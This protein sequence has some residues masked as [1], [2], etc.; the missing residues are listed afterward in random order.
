MSNPH[1]VPNLN[2]SQPSA[3]NATLLPTTILVTNTTDETELLRRLLP[4]NTLEE[5]PAHFDIFGALVITNP[6]GGE[7]LT[8][9]AY[10]GATVLADFSFPVVVAPAGAT[11]EIHWW[12]SVYHR[13]P[14][15][16]APMFCTVHRGLTGVFSPLDLYS[17]EDGIGSEAIDAALIYRFTAEFD[18]ATLNSSLSITSGIM[19]QG[20]L[21]PG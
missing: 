19:D 7:T 15:Q 2:P 8:L 9:R 6:A 16:I 11:Y 21:R 14:I 1:F 10:L 18:A 20:A 3:S 4:G 5:Q 12:G 13:P 17:A